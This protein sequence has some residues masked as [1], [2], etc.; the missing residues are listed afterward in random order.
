VTGGTALTDK[1]VV[2]HVSPK[3][4]TVRAGT[5][6]DAKLVGAATHS[7][8]RAAKLVRYFPQVQAGCGQI[9]QPLLVSGGPRDSGILQDVHFVARTSSICSGSEAFSKLA[10]PSHPDPV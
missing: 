9:T 8:L 6:W 5:Y 3:G 10:Q 7:L 1:I 4:L 2:A